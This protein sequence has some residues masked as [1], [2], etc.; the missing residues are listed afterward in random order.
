V[1]TPEGRALLD[2]AAPMEEAAL[3]LLNRL[4][5]AP[6]LAGPVRLTTTRPLADCFLVPRLGE[7]ASTH[8]GIDLEVLT[9]SRPFS[10]AR[11]EADLALRLGAPGDSVLKGRRVAVVG[12]G[13]YGAGRW[14]DHP[15]PPLVGF[16]SGS[17][18]VPQAAWLE[19]FAAGRRV[20]FRSDSWTAQAEAAAAGL[21]VA[22][23]PDYVAAL[24]PSLERFVL[25]AA[26]PRTELWLLLRP[27]LASTPRVRA[28]ADFL[29]ELCRMHA[30]L[31]LHD[32]CFT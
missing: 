8:P 23:L 13:F 21:G 10:L 3:A 25:G 12:H 15:Q 30:G 11:R 31:L 19:R 20:A 24:H 9:G 14:R 17:M 4:D 26:P 28:V 5:H 29:A 1:P 6:G 27:D 2:A 7:L 16:D 32:D 18:A 22:L